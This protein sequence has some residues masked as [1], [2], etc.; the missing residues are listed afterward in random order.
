MTFI[1][2]RI[3]NS[4]GTLLTFYGRQFMFYHRS[5]LLA[6]S[7]TKSVS[8]TSFPDKCKYR[9]ITKK[10]YKSAYEL[11]KQDA[12][13]DTSAGCHLYITKPGKGFKDHSPEFNHNYIKGVR[14]FSKSLQQY[15]LVIIVIT[16]Y[17]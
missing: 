17:L 1:H 14:F 7:M 5:C 11:G 16:N 8:S 9:L 2:F 10:K 4:L 15:S 12:N 13:C 6:F 3:L